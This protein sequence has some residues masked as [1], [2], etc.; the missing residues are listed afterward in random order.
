M[1]WCE[2]W[3]YL[4]LCKNIN[5][6]NKNKFDIFNFD[7]TV[8]QIKHMHHSH[9]HFLL[10]ARHEFALSFRIDWPRCSWRTGP[11]AGCWSRS[12]TSSRTRYP[13]VPSALAAEAH[14]L[15]PN[16]L[17]PHTQSKELN[18]TI[19]NDYFQAYIPET[20]NLNVTVQNWIQNI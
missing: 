12:D 14:A 1:Y 15:L 3:S 2:M 19:S 9:P 18:T 16:H 10:N 6:D 13:P 7:L 5:L 17:D 20:V 8:K 4:S 11:V